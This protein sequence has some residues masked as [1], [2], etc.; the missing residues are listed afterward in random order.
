MHNESRRRDCEGSVLVADQ[1]FTSARR[2]SFN[3][4]PIGVLFHVL[5]FA[6]RLSC[7][8]CVRLACLCCCCLCFYSLPSQFLSILFPLLSFRFPSLPFLAFF[9][10]IVAVLACAVLCC[11]TWSVVFAAVSYLDRR[12]SMSRLSSALCTA[13][14]YLLF[15]DLLYMVA[16]TLLTVCLPRFDCLSQ[17]MPTLGG[18]DFLRR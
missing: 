2:S 1:P 15:I 12:M 8:V 9:I 14:F 10:H 13:C 6:S 18:L 16:V 17:S 3:S 4:L 5:L 7:G 11:V